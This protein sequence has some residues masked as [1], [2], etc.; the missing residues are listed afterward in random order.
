MSKKNLLV[1]IKNQIFEG[2]NLSNIIIGT[3]LNDIIY[4]SAG[5]DTL[6]GG[7]GD[8][9]LYGGEGDDTF[10]WIDGGNNKIY[11]GPG[12]DNLIIGTSTIIT[13]PE[14]M[15]ETSGIRSHRSIDVYGDYFAKGTE[16]FYIEYY[17][18]D[19]NGLNTAN[20]KSYVRASGIEFIDNIPIELFVVG[21]KEGVVKNKDPEG[22]FSVDKGDELVIDL[23]QYGS[24]I[25]YGETTNFRFSREQFDVYHKDYPGSGSNTAGGSINIMSQFSI[26]TRE[27]VISVVTS[28]FYYEV[29]DGLLKITSGYGKEHTLNLVFTINRADSEGRY[30]E[31]SIK[32]QVFEISVK[33]YSDDG[34]INNIDEEEIKSNDSDIT[35]KYLSYEKPIDMVSLI[36]NNSEQ[37]NGTLNYSKGNDIIVLTGSGNTERGLGGDDYYLIS[38]LIPTNSNINIID[39]SGLNKIQIPDGTFIDKTLFTKNAVRI[40]LDDSRVITI[41]GADKFEY[42]LGAN[43]TSGD[44]SEDLSFSDFALVFGLDNILNS[45]GTLDGLI[46]ESYVL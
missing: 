34:T 30:I 14:Q 9:V 22:I 1:K 15:L 36:P 26:T 45:S 3:E 21:D 6:D 40:T 46:T 5:N 28:S 17:P 32:N 39:T 18:N 8:D 4:G 7:K 10:K 37:L 35:I 43:I 41:N 12:N 38:N 2:D 13:F 33:I 27:K 25:T 11:G 20:A 24:N 23:N 16:Y 42:N 31:P 19:D 29:K 44:R